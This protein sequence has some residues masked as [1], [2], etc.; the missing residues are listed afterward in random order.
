M[1]VILISGKAGH[2]KDT[3]A[4]MLKEQLEAKGEKVFCPHFADLVKYYATKYCNWDG[5]KDEAGRA[6]L[7]KIGNNTFRQFDPDYW[8]RITAE[9]VKV[10]GDYFGYTYAIIAD[11][12][13]PNEI[14]IIK[15]YNESVTTVR[16][17]RYNESGIIWINPNM[18]EEQL[19]N[20]SEI[21]LDGYVFDYT[22][23]N[24]SLDELHESAEALLEDLTI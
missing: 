19:Q 16:I 23:I 10:M 22:V 9:C 17:S 7:Q 4:T 20:E 1:K 12:R 21:A 15:Q 2:G 24:S 18:T 11:T 6:L 8:A 5:N 14:D 13:Y 3:F